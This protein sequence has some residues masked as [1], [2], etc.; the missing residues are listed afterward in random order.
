MHYK[1]KKDCVCGHSFACHD[2]SHALDSFYRKFRDCC[3]CE[4]KKFKA[5][6]KIK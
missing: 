5:K 1:I 4:C 3:E 6:D 2:Y